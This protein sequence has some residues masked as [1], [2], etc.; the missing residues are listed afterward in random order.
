MGYDVARLGTAD[1]WSSLIGIALPGCLAVLVAVLLK[2]P[3]LGQDPS[4]VYGACSGLCV[5]LEAV[6][7]G[8]GVA[9]RRTATGKAGLDIASVLLPL[10]LSLAAILVLR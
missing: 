8:C 1:L 10:A 3:T 2:N 7:V 9:A 4:P 5:I 6:A